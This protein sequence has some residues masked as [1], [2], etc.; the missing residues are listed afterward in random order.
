MVI[1]R[2]ISTMELFR[3]VL[4]GPRSDTAAMP[5]HP[6]FGRRRRAIDQSHQTHANERHG[7]AYE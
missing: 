6:P 7:V 5:H 3:N 1:E 4:S 2:M